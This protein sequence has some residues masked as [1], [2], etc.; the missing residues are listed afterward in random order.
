MSSSQPKSLVKGLMVDL[1][2]EEVLVDFWLVYF[3]LCIMNYTKEFPCDVHAMMK[4]KDFGI[5]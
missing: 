3:N 4:A 1:S 2:G 5:S